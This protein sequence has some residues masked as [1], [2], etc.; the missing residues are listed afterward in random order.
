MR[1]VMTLLL[2]AVCLC[3]EAHP[4]TQADVDAWL[5]GLV[6]RAL[7]AGDIAGGVVVIVK[8]GEILTERGFGYADVVAKV[9]VDSRTTVFRPGSISKTFTWTAVMQLVEQGKLDL[10]ADINR[11][12]DFSIPAYEGQPMTMRNVMTHSTGFE[13]KIKD[14]IGS[15]STPSLESYVKD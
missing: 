11:Y 9:P 14:I 7:Q 2:A 4:L 13:E 1:F 8:D 5:D 3:A 6:P 15:K 12:L 10:D